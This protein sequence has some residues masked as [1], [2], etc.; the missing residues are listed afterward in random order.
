MKEGAI[1]KA[2]RLL[3]LARAERKVLEQLPDDCAPKNLHEGYQVQSRLLELI[4]DPGSG[5]LLG[6]TNP[7]MQQ[8]FGAKEPYFARLLSTGYAWGGQDVAAETFCTLGIECELTFE[9][10]EDLPLLQRPRQ[11]EEVATAI[12]SIHPSIEVVNAHFADWLN[13]PLPSIVA[14]NGTDGLLVIGEGMNWPG[15]D[16]VS[17][18]V[19]LTVNWELARTGHTKLVMGNPL[20]ALTWLSN[21]LNESGQWLR[22]GELINSGTCTDIYFGEAGETL[23]AT[24]TG[25]GQ[26]SIVLT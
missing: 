8:V 9:M 7:S 16:A 15:K 26:V 5:W 21:K 20:T 2:A 12:R 22:A 11:S 14:D 1:E 19:T 4:G 17:Y 18:E 6:L 24:F 13:V 23:T 3:L 25:L 10:G